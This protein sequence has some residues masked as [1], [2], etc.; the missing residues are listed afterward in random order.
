V[1]DLLTTEELVEL[2]AARVAEEG[3]QTAFA[4]KHVR[5]RAKTA[6]NYISMV[7]SGA[8]KPGPAIALALGYR[9]VIRYEPRK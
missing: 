5:S 3:S 4:R 2:L 7:L 8:R 6:C 9:K 1:P